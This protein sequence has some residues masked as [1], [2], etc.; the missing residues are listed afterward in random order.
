MDFV[1]N[2]EQKKAILRFVRETITAQFERT[3]RPA[4]DDMGGMLNRTG[5]C[6][7]TLET[8][9]GHQLRGCIG[10][11]VA[12]EPLNKNLERNALNAAFHDPRF[13][14][15]EDH[16]LDEIE[17]DV[18]IL[19]P[20]APIASP[21]DFIVGEHGI[22]LECLGRHAV[23]LPQVA[24]EQ[25]W[26]RVQTLSC[27]SQKAGLPEDAWRRPDAKFEV[28]TAIVFGEKDYK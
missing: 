14:A 28:F 24:P 7:V 16:E 19:T 20:M 25:G 27:L 15:V 22:V 2:D 9:P 5:A 18:S 21:E 26:N 1:F 6:F 3:L 13:P 4:L 10:N 17:I 8:V 12:V 11:I 23:F